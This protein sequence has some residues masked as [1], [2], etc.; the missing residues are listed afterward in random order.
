MNKS[1]LQKKSVEE[2]TAHAK[3]LKS[4]IAQKGFALRTG[5]DKQA[6]ELREMKKELAQTLTFV[7]Q[8]NN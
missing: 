4:Q 1:E 6:H 7:T 3:E 8:K 2:L 5:G